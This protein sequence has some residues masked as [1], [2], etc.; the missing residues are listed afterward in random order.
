MLENQV[1][2]IFETILDEKWK[3]DLIEME[4]G[5]KPRTL[6]EF[7]LDFLYMTHGL[8]TLACKTLSSLIMALE[9]LNGAEKPYAILFCRMLGVF[10]ESPID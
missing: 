10:T 6:A 2:K 8:K 9:T 7:T 1:Y 5:K 4:A 3:T